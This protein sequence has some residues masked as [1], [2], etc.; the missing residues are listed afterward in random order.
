[1]TTTAGR[2]ASIITLGFAEDI[3]TRSAGSR[4]DVCFQEER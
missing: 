1:M 4:E 3:V 2:T